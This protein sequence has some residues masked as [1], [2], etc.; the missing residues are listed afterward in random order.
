MNG[1]INP[2]SSSSGTGA[3]NGVAY[4]PT[5]NAATTGQNTETGQLLQ[6][7]QPVT[8]ASFVDGTSKTVLAS[9]WQR[10]TGLA[11]PVPTSSSFLG[12]V[13]NVTDAPNQYA[14]QVSANP[15]TPYPDLLYAQDCSAQSPN[16]SQW[17]WK[18]DWW[19]SGNSCTYS[20]TQL[21]NRASCYYGTGV[22]AGNLYSGQ[23]NGVVNMLAASSYHPGGVNTVFADGSVRFIKDVISPYIWYAIATPQ[24]RESIDMSGF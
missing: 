11:P 9:E 17:T 5:N 24:G 20:H 4:Y 18:G 10:G 16:G 1:G 23:G 13:Y 7:E 14:G 6:A 12:N 22:G 8:F 3:T 19:V 2:F 21:P 15:E